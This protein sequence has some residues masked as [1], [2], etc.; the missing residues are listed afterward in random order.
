MMTSAFGV[1]IPM[2][3]LS[4]LLFPIASMPHLIQLVTYAIP[5]RYYAEILRGIFLKGAGIDALWQEATALAG[6]GVA[7]LTLASLRFQKRL[8]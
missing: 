3:Y 5:L 6:F 4:G 1:M 2:I 8:D 7:F